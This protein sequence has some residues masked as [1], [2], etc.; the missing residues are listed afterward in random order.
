MRIYS[1]FWPGGVSV[2][3]VTRSSEQT[4]MSELTRTNVIVRSQ[5]L[6]FL[7]SLMSRWVF[8]LRAEPETGLSKR[9]RRQLSLSDFQLL[10]VGSTLSQLSVQSS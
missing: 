7:I 10:C 1:D 8:C 2:S 6:S 4:I 5:E 3:L 9:P